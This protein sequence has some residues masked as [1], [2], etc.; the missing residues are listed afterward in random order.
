[1]DPNG[2]VRYLANRVESL[3]CCFCL[4]SY[5]LANLKETSSILQA[6]GHNTEELDQA[7]VKARDSIAELKKAQ[8]RA[9]DRFKN[10]TVTFIVDAQKAA[11]IEAARLQ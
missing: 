2:L 7:I 4:F 8:E 3:K 10:S 9:I 1:M 6:C 5:E 11:E